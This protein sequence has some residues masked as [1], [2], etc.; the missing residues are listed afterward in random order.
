[1]S[2]K[3][4]LILDCYVDPEGGAGNYLRWLDGRPTTVV[5]PTREPPPPDPR[6]FAGVI[7]TGSSACLSDGVP[8]AGPVMEF[9]RRSVDADV[10]YLGVCFG[11]QLLAEAV[12]GPGTVRKME[13]PEVGWKEVRVEDPDDPLLGP[14]A[15]SFLVF[16]SHEDEVGSVGSLRGMAR[17]DDCAFAA[18]RVPGRRAWGV[19]FHAEMNLAEATYVLHGR[20]RKHPE[21]ALDAEAELALS[22]QATEVG[23][24]LV[25]RW[26]GQL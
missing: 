17:S 9:A 21:L 7:V 1:M 22:R 20:V 4:I 23:A 15:P 2:D 13:R 16:L 19:Q 8:W 14:L 10:P 18:L 6:S 25:A 3:P 12:V 26:L 5:R 24:D 11:H